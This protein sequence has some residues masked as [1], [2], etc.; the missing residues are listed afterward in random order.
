MIL[1]YIDNMLMF[2][3]VAMHVVDIGVHDK[4][5]ISVN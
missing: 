5:V 1:R 3:Y 2:V 4:E